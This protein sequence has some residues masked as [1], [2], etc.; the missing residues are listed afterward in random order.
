MKIFHVSDTHLGYQ[1]YRKVSADTGLNQREQDIYSSFTEFVKIA[2][3]EK[4]DLIV[5]AGDLFDSVRPSNRAIAFA[6]SELL[7]LSDS[8]IPVIIISG[9]HETPR[10]KE[11]GSIFRVFEHISGIYPVYKENLEFIPLNIDGEDVVVHA[12]PHIGSEEHFR[13]EF[14]KMKP[15]KKKINIA[16]LH[17]SLVGLDL[18]Y[19][20]GE[21]NEIRISSRILAAGYDYVALGHFHD[22]TVIERNCAYSGSTERFSFTEAG[23]PKGF[24]EL[25]RKDDGFQIRFRKLGT[26]DMMDLGILDARNMGMAEVVGGIQE[27]IEAR[28]IEMAIARLSVKNVAREVYRGLDHTSIESMTEKALHFQLNWKIQEDDVLG[29]DYSE[30]FKGLILE[31]RDFVD[32]SIEERMDKDRLKEMGMDFLKKAGVKE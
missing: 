21:F 11:T 7:R 13:S 1:N 28:S 29:G 17:G 10:L 14:E 20:T 18:G 31:F 24:V 19:L 8:G 32:N 25:D 4:P 22:Y 6:L 2:L 15:R 12:L 3:K 27:R 5:H 26:R 9:N 16:V 23:K 30:Q